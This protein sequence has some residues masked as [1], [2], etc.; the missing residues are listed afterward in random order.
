M[1]FVLATG[2]GFQSERQIKEM[3]C[4]LAEKY[5]IQSFYV[6]KYVMH[7]MTGWDFGKYKLQAWN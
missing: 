6:V 7:L 2:N 4:A 1:N 5:K 3:C